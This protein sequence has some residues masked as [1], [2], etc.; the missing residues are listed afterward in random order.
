[1]EHKK[2]HYDDNDI[3]NFK[4][5]LAIKHIGP[6]IVEFLEQENAELRSKLT[7]AIEQGFKV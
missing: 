2:I 1:M 6:E 7:R 3:R 5:F 4:D